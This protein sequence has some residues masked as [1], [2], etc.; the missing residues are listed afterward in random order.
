MRPRYR[1]HVSYCVLTHGFFLGGGGAIHDSTSEK[2]VTRAS[3][4]GLARLARRKVA[5]RCVSTRPKKAATHLD[6][7]AAAGQLHAL[8]ELLAQQGAAVS[9][10]MRVCLSLCSFGFR[11]CF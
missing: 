7:A 8:A 4:G 11:L 1:V 6:C 5:D 10:V 3:R 9:S 2:E